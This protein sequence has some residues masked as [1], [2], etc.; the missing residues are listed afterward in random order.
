MIRV[1]AETKRHVAVGFKKMFFPANVKAKEIVSRAEFGPITSITARHPQSLPPFED[2]GDPRKMV[3]FLDHIVHPHSV[4][5]LLGGPIE[6]IFVNRNRAVGSAIVSIR[7][8]SGAVGNLHLSTGQSPTS[9]LERLEIIGDGENLVIE[10]NVRLIH[11]TT[12]VPKAKSSTVVRV[13]ILVH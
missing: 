3:S 2:R 11:Y 1:S 8:T 5:R 6:W 12:G 7:F 9:F 4:L 10:N 13:T